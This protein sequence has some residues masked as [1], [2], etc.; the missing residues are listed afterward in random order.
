MPARKV[1]SRN[2]PET[3]IVIKVVDQKKST[4]IKVRFL[5]G[6]IRWVENWVIVGWSKV[7]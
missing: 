3:M 4:P 2:T 1:K 5:G 7:I 6:F